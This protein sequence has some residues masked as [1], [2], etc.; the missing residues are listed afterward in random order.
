[1]SSDKDADFSEVRWALEALSVTIT[2]N[3]LLRWTN[4]IETRV[5]EK[6]GADVEFKGEI[7]QGQFHIRF[8]A[9][10]AGDVDC[11]I[12]AIRNYTPMMHPATAKWFEV[13]IAEFE[14]GRP[15]NR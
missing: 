2:P 7:E 10:K 11:V 9:K 1:M 8:N 15:A 13:A 14:K 12:R 6:C 4:K 3:S 5:H